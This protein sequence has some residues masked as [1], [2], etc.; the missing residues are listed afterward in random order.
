MMVEFTTSAREIPS[1]ARPEANLRQRSR[2]CR[3]VQLMGPQT[4]E[5]RSPQTTAARSRKLSGERGTQLAEQRIVPSMAVE[6]ERERER[7]QRRTKA[8]PERERL[9]QFFIFLSLSINA[10]TWFGRLGLA[11]SPCLDPNLEVPGHFIKKL[12]S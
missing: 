1:W 9:D 7:Y 12:F 5:V 10:K 8:T 6:R 3:Q 2:V 11:S 4:T